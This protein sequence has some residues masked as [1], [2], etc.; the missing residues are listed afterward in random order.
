M[1]RSENSVPMPPTMRAWVRQHRG[2]YKSSLKLVDSLRTPPIPGPN[3][4]DIVV[5][6]SYA[7]LEFSIAHTMA[8]FPALPFA[9]PLVP[10]I[11]VSGTIAVAGGKAPEELRQPGTRVLAMTDPTSMLF[12]GTGALKEYMR[13]PEAYVVPLSEPSTC[14]GEHD[15]SGHRALSL[16]QGAGLISNGSAALATVRAAKVRSGQRVLVNGASGSVGHIAAQLCRARGAF[17]VGVASG[18]NEALVRG[19]G[20]DEFVDYKK[21]VSLPDY[22]AS[23]YGSQPFDSILDCVGSQAL[24]ANSPRYLCQDGRFVNIGAFDMEDGI[25][26]QLAQWFMNSWCPWGVPRSYILFSNTPNIQEVLALVNMVEQGKLKLILDS[27]FE[28]G[29][30]I[31]AYERVTSKRA[32]GKVLIRICA[33]E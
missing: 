32:R 11:C 10:E 22:F 28:M 18:A 16:A 6:V 33:E 8:F 27:E 5:R 14:L 30:L 12:R 23:A 25:L 9:P 13:L 24:Y 31:E 29:D 4:S 17:V 7:A 20:I 2:P 26:K 15:V 21:H 3:S 1:P 19:Y